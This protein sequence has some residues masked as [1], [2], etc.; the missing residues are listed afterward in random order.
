MPHCYIPLQFTLFS[1]HR[2]T[3]MHRSHHALSLYLVG[4]ANLSQACRHRTPP[5]C[6]T[7]NAWRIRRPETFVLDIRPAFTH[8]RWRHRAIH[9]WVTRCRPHT[10]GSCLNGTPRGEFPFTLHPHPYT[11]CTPLPCGGSLDLVVLLHREGAALPVSLVGC[12]SAQSVASLLFPV[13]TDAACAP[14]P[15]HNAPLY[16]WHHPVKHDP[17]A[18]ACQM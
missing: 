17:S 10:V 8:H 1:R 7:V 16:S 5:A 13:T 3:H 9:A 14:F 18:I 4:R 15:T 11:P 2:Y 12:P 6:F